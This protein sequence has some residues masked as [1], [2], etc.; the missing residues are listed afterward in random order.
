MME[1]ID[2]A[3]QISNYGTGRLALDALSIVSGVALGVSARYGISVDDNLGTGMII[4]PAIFRAYYE[5][6]RLYASPPTSERS[7]IDYVFRA[8]GG[9]LVSALET[10]AIG[11]S[12][13]RYP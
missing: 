3:K 13:T 10:I 9:F 8:G 1:K 4:L 2:L 6:R 11:T 5:A 7:E 12:L